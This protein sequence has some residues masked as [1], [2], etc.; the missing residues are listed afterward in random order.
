MARRI[1]SYR[2]L[3]FEKGSLK[4][5]PREA[6]AAVTTHDLP[7]VAGLWSGADLEAQKTIGLSPNE[8]G[9][10]EIRRRVGRLARA[11][12]RTPVATVIARVHE[13]LAQAPSR[14]ITATLDDAMAVEERPNMPATSDERPNWSLA[15]PQPIE[16]LEKSPLAQRIARALAKR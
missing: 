2:L 5:Y 6:L 11:T 12:G 7:T 3:W 8:K 4:R 1:L 10:R 16:T 9:T 15:L 14:V 13:A